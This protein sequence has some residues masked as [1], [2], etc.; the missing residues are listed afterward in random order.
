M[1]LPK[2]E[3]T[4]SN[5]LD[6]NAD[7]VKLQRVKQFIQLNVLACLFELDVVLLQTMKCK[8]G[9]VID[10]NLERILHKLFADGTHF[11]R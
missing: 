6:K 2:S 5:R 7:L 1:G 11:L 4:T 10:K 3:D 8:L 9:L